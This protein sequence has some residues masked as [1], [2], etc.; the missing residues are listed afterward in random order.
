M[1]SNLGTVK[2]CPS[3][4]QE[5]I[6]KKTTTETYSDRCAKRFCEIKQREKAI[7]RA[8]VETVRRWLNGSLMRI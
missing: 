5:F 1:S 4:R 7:L 8:E 6:A 2:V 3:C